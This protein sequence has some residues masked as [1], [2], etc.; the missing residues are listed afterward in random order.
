M[1]LG[2]GL[3][4]NSSQTRFDPTSLF[5]G[6][7]KGFISDPTRLSSLF[8]DNAGTTPVTT[9]GQTIGL[10][11]DISGNAWD[12]LQATA[13]NRPTYQVDGNGRPYISY[14][15]TKSLASAAFDLSAKG[16]FTLVMG[17]YK[18]A[19]TFIGWPLEFGTDVSTT[20]GFAV[21]VPWTTAIT[22]V[23]A[24]YRGATATVSSTQVDVGAAPKSVVIALTFNLTASQI[25]IW[26]NGV[27]AAQ[28]ATATGGGTFGSGVL[29]IG[30]RTAGTQ[31]FN[32][33]EYRSLGIE[34]VLSA[35]DIAR[36]TEWANINTG[37]F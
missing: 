32:G 20:P 24:Q 25:N 28:V 37:A 33:R 36:V 30:T 6:G 10:R 27:Q 26:V 34:G 21:R 19:D 1:N 7:L 22:T 14:T 29:T 8:Q 31:G 23:G 16:S 13:G 18:N 9:V 17:L 11:K 3:G 35:A 12:V 15:S 4:V 5:S 2:I